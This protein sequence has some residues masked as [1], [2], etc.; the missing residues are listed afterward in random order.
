[1]EIEF[2]KALRVGRGDGR[3]EMKGDREGASKMDLRRY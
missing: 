1:M 3:K 2:I